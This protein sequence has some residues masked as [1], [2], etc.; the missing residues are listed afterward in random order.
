MITPEINI[1]RQRG[2]NIAYGW[3]PGETVTINPKTLSCKWVRLLTCLELH[4][5]VIVRETLVTG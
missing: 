4:T 2:V 1:R 3:D 5:L